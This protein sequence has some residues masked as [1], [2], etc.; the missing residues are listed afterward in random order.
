MTNYTTSLIEAV[1]SS[2]TTVMKE[3][4]DRFIVCLVI[5]LSGAKEIIRKKKN[6][7]LIE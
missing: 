5:I 2:G 3:T 6:F 4:C 1:I 7:K